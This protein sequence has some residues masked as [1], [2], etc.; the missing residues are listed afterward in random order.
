MR[1][2][3]LDPRDSTGDDRNGTGA[4]GD[5]RSEREQ[6]SPPVRD[7]E[8]ATVARP[9][10]ATD[11]L[12]ADE[13]E[14]PADDGSRS[15]AG[16]AADDLLELLS[17]RRRRYLWRALRREGAELELSDASRRIAAWENGVDIKDVEYDQRKSVYNSLHQFHCPKMADAGLIEFDKRSSTV[18]L[19][20][21]LPPQLTVTVEPDTEDVRNTACG[22]LAVAG[23][24]VLGAWALRLPVFG[25][26]SLAAVGL[27][28]GIG[29]T[30]ALLVY[31]LF[32][33]TEYGL[34]LAD[35][36]SRVDG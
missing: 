32:V 23:G 12:A 26:L 6:S 19:A 22:A 15:A 33:R 34:S 28:L 3:D 17:N 14:S 9:A 21:E 16:V 24:V 25:T 5:G 10:S 11:R 7:S 4:G 13:G 36:L 1:L 30:A 29:A 18:R 27:S 8:E 35:A 2:R 31:S 20:T